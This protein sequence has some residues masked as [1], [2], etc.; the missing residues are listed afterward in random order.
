[1]AVSEPAGQSKAVGAGQG[2]NMAS[3]GIKREMKETERGL[4]TLRA[5]CCCLG[6]FVL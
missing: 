1:M 2:V 4:K 3:A 6:V 5:E